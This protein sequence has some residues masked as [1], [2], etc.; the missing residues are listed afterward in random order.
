MFQMYDKVN[1]ICEIATIIQHV[2]I[3]IAA[4]MYNVA[5]FYNNFRNGMLSSNRPANVTLEFSVNYYLPVD[6]NKV[7]W[8]TLVSLYNCYVSYNLGFMLC[9]HDLQICV[10]VFH[11]WGH[12]NLFEHN[13]NNFPRPNAVN[14][15]IF[16][17]TNEE[18]KEVTA[19][20]KQ[21][22]QYYIMIKE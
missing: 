9:C 22:I 6:Q 15:N 20:L 21:I 4:T 14:A 19:K 1:R 12:L 18:M 7:G 17:Y 2:Q 16:R 3:Y 8:F 10:F 11:I 5:P 13:L